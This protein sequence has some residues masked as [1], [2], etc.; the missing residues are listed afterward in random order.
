MAAPAGGPAGNFTPDS[1]TTGPEFADFEI[2]RHVFRFRLTDPL[3]LHILAGHD[4]GVEQP[5]SSSGS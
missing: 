1:N 5:G 3:Q 2:S 4:R